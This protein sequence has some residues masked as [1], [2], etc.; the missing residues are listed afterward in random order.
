M[1][2]LCLAV[3][4]RNFIVFLLG[5]GL[6][7][8]KSDT[9]PNKHPQLVCVDLRFSNWKA[10]DWNYGN[11]PYV[12]AQTGAF[13]HLGSTLL[14]VAVRSARR[15]V[16]SVDGRHSSPGW[17]CGRLRPPQ[18]QVAILHQVRSAGLCAVWCRVLGFDPCPVTKFRCDFECY[19]W[20]EGLWVFVGALF[21]GVVSNLG[22]NGGVEQTEQ[23]VM[24]GWLQSSCHGQVSASSCSGGGLVLL[25]MTMRTFV[26]RWPCGG[27]WSGRESSSG[28]KVLTGW[29]EADRGS[30]FAGR[31]LFMLSG[32]RKGL[33]GLRLRLVFG[34]S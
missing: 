4:F 25:Q 19:V 34:T 31:I 29:C 11:R 2:L 12:C 15:L 3:D 13:K 6:G 10:E 20:L 18:F 27:E 33:F 32:N 1:V 5:R 30:L 7:T 16:L 28:L 8:L 22:L 14:M 9:V 26:A 23:L 17:K 24:H 21:E